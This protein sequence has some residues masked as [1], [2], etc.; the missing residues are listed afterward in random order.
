M[1]MLALRIEYLTRRAVAT[2]YNNRDQAEWPPH[3]A[4]VFSALV[5]TW[6]EG[7]RDASEREALLWLEQQ[8]FPR[9]CASDAARRDV[10][11]SYV[12]VN[13][14]TV[15]ANIDSYVIALDEREAELT[16]LESTG[17]EGRVISKARKEVE[18]ARA[19]LEKRARAVVSAS[20]GVPATARKM[21]P[22][23]RVRQARTFPS[24]T[25]EDPVIYLVWEA[26]PPDRVRKALEALAVRLVRIGHSSSLVSCRL[27]E[28]APAATWVPDPDGPVVLR[29]VDEG[30]VDRLDAAF[31]RHQGVEPRVLPA[32][33][34]RYRRARDGGTRELPRPVMGEDWIVFRRIS[35]P[36]LPPWR[37][38]EVARALRGA[39]MRHA[40][41]PPWPVLSGHAS[42]GGP[43]E[44][45]HVAYV[46]LPWVG[47]EHADGRILG[48]ALVLP[49]DLASEA[50]RHVLRAVGH[51]E[52][53]QALED[54][55]EPGLPLRLGAA[56]VLRVEPIAGNPTWNLAPEAW[57][58]P[59]TDWVSATPVALDRNPG[60]LQ[61]RDPEKA[62][63]ARREAEETIRAAC[64]RIG[65]PEP[66]QVAVEHRP[67]IVGAAPVK[68]HPPF[69]RG[70]GKL[71]RVQ[72]H[73]RLRFNER[74]YGPVLLGAGRYAGLGLF[75]PVGEEA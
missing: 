59:A 69:P 34:G 5:A 60:D 75:R 26:N 10:V 49:R 43:S 23:R 39:L 30:Q 13:D 67:P 50:R 3:P 61:S 17:T 56:G 48:V 46:A 72:V 71:R 32:R 74:V 45:P 29:W 7:D 22:D 25:P 33:F 64:V 65:L 70:A 38:A 35:G 19:A 68:R 15:L 58:G 2:E 53:A 11:P 66:V 14:L 57:C 42:G 62:A 18:K 41:Q 20:G 9:I 44:V 47:R 63:R 54:P 52:R 55:M 4:R 1:T 24:V 73:V 27:V 37:A 21:L 40:E 8:E 51:W 36:R 12:P 6:A 31:E 16:A 28:E